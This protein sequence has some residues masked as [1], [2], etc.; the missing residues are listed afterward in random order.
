MSDQDN[1]GTN[2]EGPDSRPEDETSSERKPDLIPIPGKSGMFRLSPHLFEPL[3]EMPTGMP[4]VKWGPVVAVGIKVEQ[5]P[6]GKF[7][8][9]SPQL[10]ELIAEGDTFNEAWINASDALSFVRDMYDEF[11]SP[12]PKDIIVDVPDPRD[13]NRPRP[14]ESEEEAY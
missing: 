7:V 10:P 3:P 2:G 6:D 14:S 8:A 12:L 11:D 9:T 5:R 1:N 13:F 4:E